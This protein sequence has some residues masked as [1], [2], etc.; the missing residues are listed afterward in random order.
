MCVFCLHACMCM[1]HVY[2]SGQKG[3]LDPLELE[4]QLTCEPPCGAE[5]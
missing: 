1:S 5:N 3:T 2:L 4:L